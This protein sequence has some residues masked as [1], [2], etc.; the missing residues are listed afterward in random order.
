[1]TTMRKQL[2]ILGAAACAA[3]AFA[4]DRTPEPASSSSVKSEPAIRRFSAGGLLSFSGFN[5]IDNR[6]RTEVVGTRSTVY[7]TTSKSSRLGGGATVQGAVTGHFAVSASAIL[8]RV[9]FDSNAETT[10]GTRTSKVEEVS[11]ADFWEFPVVL[12]R[13][14]KS[15][16]ESGS[17]W[18]GEAGVALR[19][20][21]N[22]RS[23]LQTTATDGKVVCC[24]ERPIPVAKRLATGFTAGAGYQFIDQFGIR[25]VPSIRYTRWTASTFDRQSIHANR[26][27]LEA[28]IAVTF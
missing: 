5:L 22:V 3:A 4:Q 7:T 15:R 24:D 13:F 12:R 19:R 17:R 1:M 11:S 26:N 20:V 14:S 25:F 6:S 10:E 28:I 9:R 2:L 18:F 16:M 23:S 21:R 8:R 27:Q